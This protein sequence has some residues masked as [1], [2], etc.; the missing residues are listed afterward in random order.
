MFACRSRKW[1]E[2]LI[3]CVLL[4]A[5]GEPPQ[6]PTDAKDKEVASALVGRWYGTQE[7][8][9]ESTTHFLVFH[10]ADGKMHAHF[11]LFRS[12]GRVEEERQSGR[13]FVSA[14]LLKVQLDTVDQAVIAKND[15]GGMIAYRVI[16]VSSDALEYAVALDERKV[17]RVRRVDD[18]FKLP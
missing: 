3:V 10:G 12:D 16:S 18:E 7:G 2:V 8:I 11:R 1:V 4:A 14:G 9:D 17:F 15:T 13:W 6:S 5:C